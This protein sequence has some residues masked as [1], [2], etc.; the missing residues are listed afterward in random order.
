M[1]DHERWEVL[2]RNAGRCA[3]NEQIMFE[4]ADDR[5]VVLE[6]SLGRGRWIVRPVPAGNTVEILEMFGTTPLPPY[7]HRADRELP[8]DRDRYQTIYAT[9]PGAV[10]APTAG[11]HF[12]EQVFEG[13]GQ[14]QIQTAVITLHV[15]LGTFA[16]VQKEDLSEHRIHSEWFELDRDAAKAVSG[17]RAEGRRI[18]AVGTTSVRVLESVA[19]AHNGDI[20][21]MSGNTDLFI[22]PPADFTV[23]GALITN[24]HLP[25]STLLM[26]VAAFCDPGGLEGIEAILG[27][28]RAAVAEKYRF[29]S[30]GDAML[31]E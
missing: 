16:P 3:I 11:L 14:K 9:M 21:P 31:I 20:I 29:Y 6:E 19:A 2:L 22:R 1:S 30:Y 4:K 27:A 5:G 23:V 12:T 18:I 28:Y 13:L 15:G 25:R 24:F 17:A 10:A 7:I 26:L 8:Q